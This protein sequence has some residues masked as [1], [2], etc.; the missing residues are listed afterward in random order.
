MLGQFKR[1]KSTMINALAGA[2]LLPVGVAPVTSV[3]TIVRQGSPP[4]TRVRSRDGDWQPIDVDQV[5]QY[6]SETGNPGNQR[7]I[8]AVEI[9]ATSPLL[10]R[11]LCLV[12][13][14][15]LGSVNAANTQET[16]DFLPHV[17]AA[18]LVVG[19]DP[20]ITGEEARLLAG[21]GASVRDL[22]VV[23]AKADRMTAEDLDEARAF[24]TKVLAATLPGRAVP[25]FTISA[26]EVL[27]SDLPTRDWTKLQTALSELALGAGAT[28][29]QTARRREI[30]ALATSLRRHLDESHGALLRPVADSERRIAKLQ[31]AAG[32][33]ERALVELRHLFDAEQKQIERRLE[34]DRMK[35][36]GAVLPELASQLPNAGTRREVFAAAQDLC[37]RRVR[38]WRDELR[39]RVEAEFTA[40][41][42]RFATAAEQV[43]AKVRTSSPDAELPEALGL[44]TSLSVPSRFF[45]AQL[46]VEAFP[47][48]WSKAAD[49]LRSQAARSRTV[50]E[51]G[52]GFLRRLLEVNAHGVV[53]DY[54]YR[55]VE[56]RRGIERAVRDALRGAAD[57]ATAASA[58]AERIRAHGQQAVAQQ[59]ARLLALRRELDATVGSDQTRDSR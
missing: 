7:G 41:A 45:F 39:P 3:V 28:L 12:D 30:A 34:A 43:T 21:L 44:E 36:V 38:A 8:A 2:S 50:R 18:M 24:T 37:E 4:A 17:D 55:I 57:A 23:I 51:R 59:A 46:N 52:E 15:G 47:H 56:S 22:F 6:V 54:V 9:E 10:E 49:R 20:P 40:A 35:F 5:S 48:W 58:R 25:V 27:A 31:R 14:P 53:G 33:A 1:G 13:T 32:E 11:G 19:A 42:K 29:V 16:R 26:Q